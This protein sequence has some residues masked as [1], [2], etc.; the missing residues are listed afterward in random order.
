[1][2]ILKRALGMLVGGTR[3]KPSFG[4]VLALGSPGV[5]QHMLR[6]GLDPR[7]CRR[8]RRWPRE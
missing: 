5:C 2:G 3:E 1:M 8:D 7:P 4:L 6:T